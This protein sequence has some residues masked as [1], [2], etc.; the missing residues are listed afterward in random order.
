MRAGYGTSRGYASRSQRAY[1]RAATSR[2][3]EYS[4]SR[5]VVVVFGDVVEGTVSGARSV[6]LNPKGLRRV[7]SLVH[8]SLAF[9]RN[10]QDKAAGG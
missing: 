3:V 4:F 8:L 7:W 9:F 10:T 6:E 2:D 5:S 1:L